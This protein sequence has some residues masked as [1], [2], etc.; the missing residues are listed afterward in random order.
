[1][2]NQRQINSSLLY[3]NFEIFL[4][5]I[6]WKLEF[7]VSKYKQFFAI[8]VLQVWTFVKYVLSKMKQIEVE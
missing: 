2:N 3:I 7:G 8:L 4:C 6:G 1:M 5:K